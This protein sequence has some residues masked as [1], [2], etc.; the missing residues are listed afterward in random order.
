MSFSWARSRSTR[1][2]TNPTYATG[3]IAADDTGLV[4]NE[5]RIVEVEIA[6]GEAAPQP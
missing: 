4:S 3:V 5:V 1:Q 6:E 2:T